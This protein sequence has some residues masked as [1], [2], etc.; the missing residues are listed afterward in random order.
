MRQWN[1]QDLISPS[2]SSPSFIQEFLHST[3]PCKILATLK[4]H[5]KIC[6]FWRHLW[7]PPIFDHLNMYHILLTLILALLHH[8]IWPFFYLTLLLRK[9]FRKEIPHL[10]KFFNCCSLF[11]KYL[12]P[13]QCPWDICW[14][15]LHK[16][17]LEIGLIQKI[18]VKPSQ[19][20]WPS[21]A[22]PILESLKLLG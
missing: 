18:L 3:S 5:L 1:I 7:I 9:T 16:I 12:V 10:K 21:H 2:K 11:V 14:G 8:V 22:V 13:S 19:T 15:L 6:H 4:S 17:K 20:L